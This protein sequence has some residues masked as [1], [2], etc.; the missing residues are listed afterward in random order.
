MVWIKEPWI[1]AAC[2][3]QAELANSLCPHARVARGLHSPISLLLPN[4]AELWGLDERIKSKHELFTLISVGICRYPMSI[5]Q[6]QAQLCSE[7]CTTINSTLLQ[8]I[9]VVFEGFL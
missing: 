2:S 6:N 9:L 3:G 1:S 7:L 4:P 8:W 5:P